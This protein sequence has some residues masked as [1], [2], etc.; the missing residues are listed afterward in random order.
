MFGAIIGDIIGSTREFNNTKDYDFEL[1]PKHSDFTDD[2]VLTCAVV[3]A[4]LTG[5]SY[6]D[7]I[8]DFA[9]RYPNRGYGGGFKRWL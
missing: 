1:F 3:N 7:C 4:I 2:T 5:D 6:K 9:S 8:I